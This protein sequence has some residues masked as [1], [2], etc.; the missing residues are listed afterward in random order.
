MKIAVSGVQELFAGLTG[1]YFGIIPNNSISNFTLTRA[2]TATRINK[3]GNIEVV[4]ANKGRIDYSL[5]TD[6][7]PNLLVERSVVNLLQWSESFDNG[8]WA[9]SLGTVTPN[10]AISPDGTLDADLFTKTSG[11]NTV[12]QIHSNPYQTTGVHTL[13]VFIKP[14]VGSQ[15]LL[16][17]D[18]AD[19]TCNFS[20]NFITKQ[21]SLTGGNTVSFNVIDYP[22]GWFR[23]VCVG[24]VL[25][26][27][28]QLNP[29]NLFSNPTG[30]SFYIWG[31][32]LQTGYVATSYIPT[33]SATITKSADVIQKT[34]LSSLIPQTKGTLLFDGYLQAGSLS[35]NTSYGLLAT[36]TDLNN[37]ILLYRYNNLI[38]IIVSTGGVSQFDTT[39]TIL[40]P[41]KNKRIKISFYYELNNCQLYINGTLI[42]T[43]TSC[44]IPAM[45][46]INVGSSQSGGLQWDGLIKMVGVSEELTDTERDQFFQYD[47]F[48][49]MASE[50]LYTIDDATN[51]TPRTY[52]FLLATGIKDQ[53]II[54]A[55]NY[56][57]TSLIS[58]GLLPE[59]IGS[60]K[61]KALYPFVGGNA[62]SHKFNFVNPADT[63]AAF[64]LSFTGSWIHSST[65]AQPNGGAANTFIR[66]SV[67]LGQN[68]LH[69]SYY[70]RTNRG[71]QGEVEMGVPSSYLLYAYTG[72]GI[73]TF[74]ALNRGES[75][76]APV[77]LTTTKLLIGSRSMSSEETYFLD[78]SKSTI[79]V[80]SSSPPSGYISLSGYNTATFP[81]FGATLTSYKECAFASIGDGLSDTEAINLNNTVN[82]FQTMLSRN[83]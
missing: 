29:I 25:N 9:K 79:T 15:I 37:R 20:Y 58:A 21:T 19:N 75:Q 71:R 78:G 72:S 8:Y 47:T 14:N 41:F 17:L 42:A 35:D 10:V 65:G 59:G 28:W 40:A 44:T 55:L 3:S 23:L 81:S 76:T 68:N 60:G 32:Q 66:P 69:Y 53:T 80:N 12:S 64:R 63:D 24:N 6:K 11:V 22:N 83:V 2:S 74:H 45:S 46:N 54:N 61:I 62:N 70:S 18:G 49:E 73:T 82:T 36:H 34:G 16:R 67:N 5:G 56:L 52:M 27:G 77:Y 43:D 38:Y 33:T 7:C 1:S 30:D 48:E 51:M 4:P 39:Y 31:V 26:T 13:S 57:D 50:M